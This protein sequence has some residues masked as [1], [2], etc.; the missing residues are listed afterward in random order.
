MNLT[1]MSL[2]VTNLTVMIPQVESQMMRTLRLEQ[3][4]ANSLV[5]KRTNAAE[6]SGVRKHA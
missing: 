6:E 5:M 2:T 3:M 4:D 1:V